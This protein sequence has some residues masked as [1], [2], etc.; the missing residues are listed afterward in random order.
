MARR[1]GA[2][3][4]PNRRY[5]NE[6]VH[7]PDMLSWARARMAGPVRAITAGGAHA[8]YRRGEATTPD[9]VSRPSLNSGEATMRSIVSAPIALSVRAGVAS[10]ANALDAQKFHQDH[11]TSGER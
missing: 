10:S 9:V 3:V 11:A 8:S 7:A 2:Q 1:E 5:A 4:I 6:R